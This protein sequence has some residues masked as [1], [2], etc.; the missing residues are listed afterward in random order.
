VLITFGTFTLMSLMTLFVEERPV[1]LREY[2]SSA[3]GICGYFF[4]KFFVE[5]INIIISYGLGFLVGYF[6]LGLRGNFIFE[7]LIVYLLDFSLSSIFLCLGAVINDPKEANGLS[8]LVLMP[9]FLFSGFFPLEAMPGWIAWLRWI[10]PLFYG[11]NMVQ[12]LEFQYVEDG[13]DACLEQFGGNETIAAF[14]CPGD[15]LRYR[16]TQSI[17]PINFDSFWTD[18]LILIILTIFFRLLALLLLRM[19]SKYVYK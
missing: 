19:N 3:Y 12:V 2:T 5:F 15:V 16:L 11:C 9:I 18:F 17:N 10:S 7:L 1:F 13:Y 4:A 6:M 14:S 8:G